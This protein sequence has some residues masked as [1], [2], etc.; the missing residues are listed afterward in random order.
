MLH[1]QCA[2]WVVLCRSGV[3]CVVWLVGACSE[4]WAE[5][6]FLTLSVFFVLC[7]VCVCCVCSM[8]CVGVVC[9]VYVVRVVYIVWVVSGV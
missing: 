8:C 2:C 5:N 9:V 4:V 6:F 7:I 3:V 1:V